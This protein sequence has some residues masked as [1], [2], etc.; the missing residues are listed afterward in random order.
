M[1][2]YLSCVKSLLNEF[3]RIVHV[4]KILCPRVLKCFVCLLCVQL[5]SWYPASFI[6]DQV[7]RLYYRYCSF[8]MGFY[9]LSKVLFKFLS[10]PN[11]QNFDSIHSNIFGTT[12]SS[13]KLYSLF[14]VPMGLAG[15][16][17]L[18]YVETM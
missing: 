13:S 2:M 16:L 17:F 18:L 5:Y 15:S 11:L 6:T 7:V 12:S 10:L 8:C 14:S 3:L 4:H 9:F 1:S